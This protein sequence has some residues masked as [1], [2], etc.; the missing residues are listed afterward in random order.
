MWHVDVYKT[1]FFLVNM[2]LQAAILLVGPPNAVPQ[3]AAR[4]HRAECFIV[5]A[6]ALQSVVPAVGGMKFIGEVP[7]RIGKIE[8]KV[9]PMDEL[10]TSQVPPIYIA[11]NIMPKLLTTFRG[12]LVENHGSGVGS[13]IYNLNDTM[14]F[15]MRQADG[16]PEDYVRMLLLSGLRQR[17]PARV[18]LT[19]MGQILGRM[20]HV[21]LR[22]FVQKCRTDLPLKVGLP[23]AQLLHYIYSLQSWCD[24]LQ[25][26]VRGMQQQ[27]CDQMFPTRPILANAFMQAADNN[28]LVASDRIKTNFDYFATQNTIPSAMAFVQQVLTGEYTRTTKS[29]TIEKSLDD[30]DG[31]AA[32]A[33]VAAA[34]EARVAARTALEPKTADATAGGEQKAD[35]EA[36]EARATVIDRIKSILTEYAE[37]GDAAEAAETAADAEAAAQAAEEAKAEAAAQAAEEVNMLVNVKKEFSHYRSVVESNLEAAKSKADAAAKAKVNAPVTRNIA[38]AAAEAAEAEAEAARLQQEAQAEAAAAE[39]AAAEAETAEA[40]EGAGG[41]LDLEMLFSKLRF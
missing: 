32:A 20:M 8:V 34:A 36:A 3:G 22:P 4:E 10:L 19:M 28:L 40:E 38:K 16:I 35:A 7:D 17:P 21:Y 24:N 39:A 1:Y 26:Y 15:I 27:F 12:L 29:V 13:G 18:D 37:A 9:K 11:P 2:A 6:A 5:F 31:G 41:P 25:K 14:S 33:A 23:A 30:A